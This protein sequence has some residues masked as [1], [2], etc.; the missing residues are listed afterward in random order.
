MT[1]RDLFDVVIVGAGISG[2]A[3]ARVLVRSNRSVVV[4]EARDR[5][6]GRLRTENGLDLGAT[7]FWPNE[8]RIKRLIAELGIATHPQYLEGDAV[9]HTPTGSTRL[10]GNPI[11][12]PSGRFVG[13]AEG[14]A[15]AVAGQLPETVVRLEHPV[16]EVGWDAEGVVV[17]TPK[18][19]FRGRHLVL[20]IPP[21]LAAALITFSPRLPRRLAEL[22]SSTPV[23]MGAITKVVARYS[24]PFWRRAGLAGAAISHAGPMGELHDMSGPEGDPAALFGFARLPGGA[25]SASEAE[26]LSQF[27]EIFG[28]EA[29]E[30][31][32]LLMHDWQVERYTSPPGVERL[33]RYE[34]FGNASYGARS[35]GGRL[36][37]ASTETAFESPGHIEGAL[38]AAERATRTIQEALAG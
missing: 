9:F 22:A 23:W 29:A 10:E 21:A 18:G 8:R 11:D 15:K 34:L 17:R 5:V 12:A 6:G 38:A 14:L 16:R 36:H 19:D 24:E 2:L 20:A 31:E 25:R 37:W 4:L 7:W 1:E 32:N 26:V 3:V 33:A 13:G 30:P 28:P 35:L 27:V